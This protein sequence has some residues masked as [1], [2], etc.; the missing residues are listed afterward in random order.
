MS[1]KQLIQLTLVLLTGL[2]ATNTA[3]ANVTWTRVM[4]TPET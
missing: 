1:R 4:A 2:L 3:R